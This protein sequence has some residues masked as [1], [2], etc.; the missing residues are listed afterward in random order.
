MKVDGNY[1]LRM[2]VNEFRCSPRKVKL[3]KCFVSVERL[4]KEGFLSMLI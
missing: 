2:I 3:S 4:Q 1:D